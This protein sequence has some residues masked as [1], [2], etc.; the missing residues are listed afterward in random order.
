MKTSLQP[1]LEENLASFATMFGSSADY[2]AK[3]I[4]IA[5]V[6]AAILL[7]DNL[8]SLQMLWELVLESAAQ[9][10]RT[11]GL[12]ADETSGMALYRH[13]T[14]DTDIPASPS[15]VE[16]LE[17]AV[18]QLTA[19][20]ALLLLDGCPKGIAF[21]VQNLKFRS[22]STPSAEGNIRGSREG[23][24]DL[25]RVNIS[26]LRR[27]VRTPD[28]V[29]ETRQSDTQTKTEYA[30]CYRRGRADPAMIA[31]LKARLEAARPPVLLDSSY[32]APWLKPERFRLFTPLGY[33]ERPAVAAAKLC[34]GKAI[35]LVNGSP[36]A[37]IV[38][39]LLAE[40]FSCLDDYGGTAY[41]AA[42]R[43]LLKYVSF[44]ITVM[45]PGVFVCSAV[46]TP[47]ILPPALL[48]K[49]AAA[50]AATPLPLFGEM[51]LV[52]LILE[53]IRE[54]G[55]RMPDSLGHSVSLVAALI[56]GDAAVGAGVLSTPVILIGAVTSIAM[57]VTP[58]LYEPASVLRILFLLAGG[59]AGPV[60]LAAALLV[61]LFSLAGPEAFG[62][63]YA[64]TLLPLQRGAFRD[65]VL[66]RDLR[67]LAQS[68]YTVQQQREEG[69]AQ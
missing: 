27:L 55:L 42:V 26:L 9:P 29:I 50:E 69:A 52:I 18:A 7:F 47:E 40:N 49:V 51:L 67:G 24:T 20:G 16:D 66:R 2:Y 3:R 34:E 63:P 35:V 6:P 61:F 45:L 17:S 62:V 19:G 46:Y 65:G 21:A 28:L 37:L 25:L 64:A 14:E 8:A 54:A 39:Y 5:G 33:T 48:Y 31:R 41:F 10:A 60:G 30:V 1:S 43:R 58:S 53:I 57:F 12:P 22:V 68:D 38:P 4:R 11:A 32:F 59:L 36:S 23:F 56:V 13:L 44:L 15:P